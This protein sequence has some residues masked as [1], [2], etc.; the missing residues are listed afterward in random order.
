VILSADP[1]VP[2]ICKLRLFGGIA[3]QEA[4]VAEREEEAL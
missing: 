2:G 3:W 1:F 4:K